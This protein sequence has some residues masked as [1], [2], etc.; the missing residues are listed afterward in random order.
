MMLADTGGS[1]DLARLIPLF[2]L[3]LGFFPEQHSFPY[4][5][6]KTEKEALVTALEYFLRGEVPPE[7]E[8]R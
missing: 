7:E 4:L 2:F 6:T 1:H 8:K 3:E 5:P